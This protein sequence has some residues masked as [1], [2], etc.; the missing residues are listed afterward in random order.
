MLDQA[1]VE[2]RDLLLYLVDASVPFQPAEQEALKLIGS[3]KAPVLL[4]LNKVDALKEK[5]LLLPLIERYGAL[6][7]FDCEIT[8][9][10]PS[11]ATARIDGIFIS[12]GPSPLLPKPRTKRP[13]AT[14]RNA[15][16]SRW[17]GSMFAWILKMKPEKASWS[18]ATTLPPAVRGRGGPACSRKPSIKS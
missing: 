16:R 13:D 3:I 11:G 8:A 12:P 6:A 4:L 5:A 14:R 17:R 7:S 2:D 1:A 15:I 10:V 18:I 9:T